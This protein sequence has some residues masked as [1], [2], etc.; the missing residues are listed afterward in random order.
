VL[1]IE[2]FRPDEEW[3]R[4]RAGAAPCGCASAARAAPKEAR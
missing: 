3:C 2:D 1:A 4:H